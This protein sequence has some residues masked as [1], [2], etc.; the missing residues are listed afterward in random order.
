MA[1]LEPRE[2][3]L[4]RQL[5]TAP[6]ATLALQARGVLIDLALGRGEEREA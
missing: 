6:Q 3:Q 4:L 5:V 2:I 1:R